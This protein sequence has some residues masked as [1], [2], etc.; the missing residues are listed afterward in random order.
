MSGKVRLYDEVMQ[1]ISDGAVIGTTSFGMGGLPEQLL[2]GLKEY[3]RQHQHP[4]AITFVATAGSGI[5]EGR[6]M[7]HLIEPGLLKRAINSY[8]GTSPLVG[9]LIQKGK[10]ESYL[11]PQGIISLLYS[12]AARKGP[13]VMSQVGIDTF[14]DPLQG[15]GKMNER[16]NKAEDLVSSIQ[17]QGERWL[18]YHPLPINV[19]FIKA[20]YADKT[21]N[22]SIKHETS[23]LEILALATAAFNAGGIVIAQVEEIVENNSLPA[24]EV[25]V[26]G[27]LVNYVVK[28]EPQYHMQTPF[29]HYQPALSNEIRV[30]LADYHATPLTLKKVIARRACLELIPHSVVNLGFGMPAEI[31]PVLSEAGQIKEYHLTTDLGGIGGM[32]AFG[33]NYGPS[34][35]PD[36]MI[37]SQDTFALYHGGGLE[38]TVI[39]F[40][41]M[42]ASG[43][44]NSTILGDLLVGPGGLIDITHG[45][46]HI[47]FVGTFVIGSKMS[48]KDG[49]VVIDKPGKSP[50]FVAELPYI[51]FSAQY[52]QRLGKRMTIIT[53][54]AVFELNTSGKL[55]LVEIAPGLDLQT[56]LLNWMEFAPE[57]SKDLKVMDHRLYQEEWSI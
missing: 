16:T 35:N 11:L 38:T 17:L 19:A 53:D 29:V 42:D 12:D 14:I 23:E 6:G 43:N 44:I 26:P 45:A 8:L 30:S 51:T 24:R 37:S 10:I 39:G 31:G 54:R 36:A 47:I 40:G 22:L 41:Q 20:T 28:S 48:I 21:G 1:H 57:I 18:H 9:Q 7:D 4:Q 2:V 55:C 3:Y 52:A 56:D 34:L 5:G 13:G 49:T 32:P 33:Y 25:T 27:I 15:G 46:K 50:K